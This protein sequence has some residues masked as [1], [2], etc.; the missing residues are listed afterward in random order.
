MAM[1]AGRF[2]RN[3]RVR[4]ITCEQS[5]QLATAHSWADERN[6]QIAGNHE[7]VISVQYPSRSPVSFPLAPTQWPIK[8][9]SRAREA[10]CGRGA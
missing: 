10:G 8:G 1:F 5:A 9:A 3:N 7:R 4:T 2:D 6:K